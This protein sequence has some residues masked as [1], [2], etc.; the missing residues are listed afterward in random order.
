MYA[1]VFGS[2]NTVIPV[3]KEIIRIDLIQNS[4][5]SQEW[6]VEITV[7]VE[8]LATPLPLKFHP[9]GDL[10]FAEYAHGTLYRLT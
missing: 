7:V 4:S 8:D 6:E 10:Y 3:G 5:N 2:W 1:T 9:N